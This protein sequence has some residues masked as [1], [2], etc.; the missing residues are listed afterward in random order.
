MFLSDKDLKEMMKRESNPFVIEPYREAQLTPNGYDM[1][2][3]VIDREG[4]TVADKVYEIKPNELI[5]VKTIE[6]LGMPNGYM[7]LMLLRSRFTRQGLLGLFAVIDSGF[8]GK[9]IAS[10]KNLSSETVPIK[11]DEGVIHMIV[12][13]MASGSETP[14]GTSD[15]HH[16]QHQK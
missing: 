5:R 10:I 15:K 9:I 12:S 6:T 2:I 13:K 8:H 7:A 1:A 14:Y 16:W 11:L 4:K 3:E